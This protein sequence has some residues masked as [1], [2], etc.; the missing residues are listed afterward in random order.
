LHAQWL[1]RLNDVSAGRYVITRFERGHLCEKNLSPPRTRIQRGI[2]RVKIVF[3]ATRGHV[4][5]LK[6]SRTNARA[7]Q[8]NGGAR[9][10]RQ[11]GA[12]LLGTLVQKLALQALALG[13]TGII[14]TGLFN[15][16]ILAV[17]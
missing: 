7:V 2:D 3:S 13:L 12:V 15:T 5:Q 1:E 9:L 16:S 8:I 17:C 10:G 6:V 11:V 4:K 14:P